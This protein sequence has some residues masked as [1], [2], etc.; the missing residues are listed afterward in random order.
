MYE[1]NAPINKY[2]IQLQIKIMIFLDIKDLKR[3]IVSKITY[4]VHK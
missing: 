1:K 4:E 2:T 3:D